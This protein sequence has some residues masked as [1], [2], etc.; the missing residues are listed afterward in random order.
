MAQKLNSQ[1]LLER[2]KLAYTSHSY[3]YDPADPPDAAAVA[4]QLGL[5]AQQVYKTLVLS[6]ATHGRPVLVMLA[7]DRQLDLKRTAAAIGQKRLE[8]MARTETER[9]TGL[10]IGGIGALALSDKRWPCYLD[11]AATQLTTMYVNAGQRGLMLGLAVPDLIAAVGAQV[12]SVT[13]D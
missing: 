12:I 9:L 10:K 6:V 7:A 1:R 2:R 13:A 8:L 11:Q 3:S 5:P 4:T